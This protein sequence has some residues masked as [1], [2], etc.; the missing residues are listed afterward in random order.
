MAARTLDRQTCWHPA[1]QINDD[2]VCCDCGAAIL[3][4]SKCGRAEDHPD[5]S[6]VARLTPCEF[7]PVGR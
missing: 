3:L 1:L 4:C 5:H 2:G 7:R 6:D